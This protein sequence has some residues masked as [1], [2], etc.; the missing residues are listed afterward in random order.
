MN[1][2]TE[3]NP[4]ILMMGC[5]AVG[6]VIAAGLLGAG[7]DVTLVTHNPAISDAIANNG[8]H[9][10]TPKGRRT[11]A[12]ALCGAACPDTSD[13]DGQFDIVLLSMKA[14]AVEDAA[15]KVEPLLGPDGYVVTLQNG[16]VEDRVAE[17]VGR[18]RV[19]GAIVGWGATMHR[20]G[21][22]EMTSCGETVI[23][24]LHGAISSRA[25]AL[26][27]ILA[28]ATPTSISTNIMG[29]LWSK[30]AIN[31]AITTL[32]AITGQKLGTLL[33]RR[34][35]RRLALAVVSEVL[36]TAESGGIGLEP[37]GGTLDLARLY[38]KP[39][40]RG[41]GLNLA[42]IPQHVIMGAVGV[43]FRRLRSSMLQSLERGRE[44]E[45]E[46]LNGYVV[47]KAQAMGIAT[48]VNT[49]LV[50]MVREIAA[51][52]RPIAPANLAELLIAA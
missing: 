44:P 4:R 7:H 25:V 40:R 16:I 50:A 10:V 8:L 20:P 27:G 41:G 11:L 49:A 9:V 48:P 14:T 32:G 34:L 24:E 18:N 29:V 6:G 35:A 43:R 19:I 26:R 47:T 30:L 38:V 42:Q 3:A 13:V 23:G 51:G 31:C 1:P 2:Y 37:V 39:T 15:H 5:G 21:I 33:R 36:D 17:I 22:Y 12:A 28:E 46:F 52:K 45:I